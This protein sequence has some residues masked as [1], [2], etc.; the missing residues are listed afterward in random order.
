MKETGQSGYAES[1]QQANKNINDKTFSNMIDMFEHRQDPREKSNRDLQST[2]YYD[3]L[4]V[5]G[6][7]R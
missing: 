5:V 7:V 1:G 2:E 4:R 3:N 6:A